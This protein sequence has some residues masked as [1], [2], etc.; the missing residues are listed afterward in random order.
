M[1]SPRLFGEVPED[2]IDA[3]DMIEAKSVEAKSVEAKSVE[4]KS[5]PGLLRFVLPDRVT[6]SLGAQ[7][8]RVKRA[9]VTSSGY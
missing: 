1:F 6:S 4:A 5:E 9:R 2:V 8:F 7:I 3:I